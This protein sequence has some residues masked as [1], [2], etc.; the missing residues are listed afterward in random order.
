MVK[1]IIEVEVQ[2]YPE[3]GTDIRVD[4]MIFPYPP[5]NLEK[6][7]TSLERLEGRYEVD[8]KS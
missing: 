5:R 6:G 3:C 7:V 4:R 8:F 1:G 2:E